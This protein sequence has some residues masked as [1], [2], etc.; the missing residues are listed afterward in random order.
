M[1]V[2][3][4]QIVEI[5][6]KA[7]EKVLELY[8]SGFDVEQKSDDSPVTSADLAANQ[9]IMTELAS[10]FPDIPIISE[11]SKIPDYEQRKNWDRFFLIDPIDGTKDFIK[12]T[13]EFTVNIGLIEKGRPV[14]GVV[15][16]P[17]LD[18]MYSGKIEEG[19]FLRHKGIEKTLPLKTFSKGKV[20]KTVIS[21]SHPCEKTMDLLAS[22]EADGV[23]IEKISVGSSLKFCYVA[24]G[25]IDIYPRFINMNE[26]DTAAAQAVVIASGAHM[27]DI[28]TKN[29]ITYNNE[30]LRIPFFICTRNSDYI[31]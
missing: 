17:A 22:W 3:R 28:K 6:D 15:Y 1:S 9:I 4:E 27:V 20:L 11:E 31:A 18:K 2:K 21:R 8:R 29:A 12:K 24:D 23:E 13:D 19:A 16:A 25:T 14:L 7:G 26:W 5:V 30:S 10:L